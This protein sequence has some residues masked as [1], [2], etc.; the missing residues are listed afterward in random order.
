M[1]KA[2]LVG[3]VAIGALIFA[4]HAMASETTQ[5]ELGSDVTIQQA[6]SMLHYIG[7]NDRF[8]VEVAPNY[9]EELG[10][11][12]KGAVGG[13]LTDAMALGLI[14]EY[15]ENKREY[16][17][18]A[19]I[20]FTDELSLVGTFGLL[21]E[22]NE[23]VDGEGREK[24]QQ[25]EYG[26]SLKGTYEVGFLSGFEL[27]GYLADAGADS[28]SVETGKL[29]GV[30]LLADLDLTSTTHIEIG[31]GYEWLEWDDTN[32]DDSRWTF[33]A[34][35]VQQLGDVISL[36]GNA[37]LGASEYV[38]GGGLAFDLSNGGLNTNT[39]G[40]NYSYIDGRNGI[41]DDQRIELSWTFGFGA[42]PTTSVASADLTDKSGTIRAAADVAMVSPA[43][44]LLNDVMKRPGFVP[45]AVLARASTQSSAPVACTL[46]FT[47]V[48]GYNSESLLVGSAWNNSLNLYVATLTGAADASVLNWQL[49]AASS[50]SSDQAAAF[51]GLPKTATSYSVESGSLYTDPYV[52]IASWQTTGASIIFDNSGDTHAFTVTVEDPATNCTASQTFTVEY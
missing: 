1:K 30:Q 14:V 2:P 47:M 13:F 41:E 7:G 10:F 18:N 22:H 24:V 31:G 11:S 40:V 39:L 4:P 48:L 32:D 52:G 28:D 34:E 51:G 9:S 43:N 12:L 8:R 50:N 42:G 26:A 45:Q 27:N 36:T 33:S 44:T 49:A 5:Y 46:A 15:G 21:E 35:A 19:G 25:M 20:Q 17:A 16:L 38:Y 6:A 37:K 29:Y 23:Y 3:S